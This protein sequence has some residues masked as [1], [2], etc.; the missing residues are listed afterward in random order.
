M[1]QSSAQLLRS[2]ARRAEAQSVRC[3]PGGPILKD[4]LFFFG[5]Y[6]GTRIRNAPEGQIAFVPTAAERKGDFSDLC[7]ARS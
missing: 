1:V 5:T 3:Q 6:Q 7:P 4:K 2:Q